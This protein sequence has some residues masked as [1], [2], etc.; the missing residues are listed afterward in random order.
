MQSLPLFVVVGD[1]HTH[2][3]PGLMLMSIVW[4]RYHN[5]LADRLSKEHPDWPDEALYQAARKRV[6]AALQVV[7]LTCCSLKTM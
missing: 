2:Q 1:P 5:A 7:E 4:F 6:T 3:N